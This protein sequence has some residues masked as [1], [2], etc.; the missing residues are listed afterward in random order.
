MD[1]GGTFTDVVLPGPDGSLQTLKLLSSPDDYGRA[2]ADGVRSVL[3]RAQV[4][5]T[6][7]DELVHGTTVATNAV[8]EGTGAPTGLLTTRGFRDVLN[9]GQDESRSHYARHRVAPTLA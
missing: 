9:E 2:I 5:G 1:V 7:V 3:E 6:A 4:A 8:L